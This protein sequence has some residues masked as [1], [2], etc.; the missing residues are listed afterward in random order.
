MIHSAIQ[1]A[2]RQD[3]DGGLAFFLEY[4]IRT[5]MAFFPEIVAPASHLG[6]AGR[7]ALSVY[8]GRDRP[9]SPRAK[10]RTANHSRRRL[11]IGRLVSRPAP[12]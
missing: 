10:R 7:R 5:L 3:G 6:D 2:R 4:F 9:P 8:S 1:A 11:W 12:R